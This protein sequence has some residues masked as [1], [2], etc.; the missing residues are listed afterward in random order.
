MLGMLAFISR[1]MQRSWLAPGPFFSLYW[2]VFTIIPLIAAPEYPVS[3]G[4]IYWIVLS[5]LAVCVGGLLG[6]GVQLPSFKSKYHEYA[7]LVFWV[8]KDRPFPWLNKLIIL[9]FILGMMVP[10]SILFSAGYLN[11]SLFSLE[12]IQSIAR[13]FSIMRYAEGYAPPLFSRLLTV[14]IYIG[15][16]LGGILY[17]VAKTRKQYLI[18][19]LPFVPALLMTVILTTK[20]SILFAILLFV[21]SAISVKVYSEKGRSN[22]SFL[23]K[24]ALYGALVLFPLIFIVSIFRA[25][26]SHRTLVQVWEHI[27]PSFFAYI[28][29]FSEWFETNWAQDIEPQMGVYS[30]AGLFDMLGIQSRAQ[31]LYSDISTLDM[32]DSNVY[33]MFRGLIQDF[34]LLGSLFVLFAFGLMAGLAYRRLTHG[35]R[36]SIAFLSCFYVVTLWGFVVSALNYNSILFALIFLL[37]YMVVAK[38]KPFRLNYEKNTT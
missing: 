37:L 10:I 22:L 11:A 33:T 14:W 32:I 5:S 3:P 35:S 9:S 20:A 18:C 4:G 12:S 7:P 6:A 26:D 19:L 21:S 31:G 2:L 34:T 38:N 16:L 8:D 27:K 36:I 25:G 24:P 15:A 17:I 28:A 13:Q 30:M 1:L 29:V 23:F